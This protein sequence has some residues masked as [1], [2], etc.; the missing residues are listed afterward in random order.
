M[1]IAQYIAIYEANADYDGDE[2][3]MKAALG[4]LRGIRLLRAQNMGGAG[5]NLGFES[6]AEEIMQLEKQ[7]RATRR[8]SF[9]KGRVTWL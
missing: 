7:L 2:T 3:K 8:N 9:T 4:A 5:G 1:T 6:I